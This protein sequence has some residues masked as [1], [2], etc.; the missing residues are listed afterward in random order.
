MSG[1]KGVSVVNGSGGI[2]RICS[3]LLTAQRRAAGKKLLFNRGSRA[4][5]QLSNLALA[6][7][8]EEV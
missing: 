7:D 6:V 4:R 5:E 2:G 1:L 8:K 3:F